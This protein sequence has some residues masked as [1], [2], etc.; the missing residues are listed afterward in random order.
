MT[1]ILFV[2]T[3]LSIIHL[4]GYVMLGIMILYTLFGCIPNKAGWILILLA[5]IAIGL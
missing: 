5:I 4:F 2:V 3:P 1:N